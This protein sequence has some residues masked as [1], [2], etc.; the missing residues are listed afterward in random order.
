[1]SDETDVLDV[2]VADQL[3]LHDFGTITNDGF[4][5][6]GGYSGFDDYPRYFTC[7]EALVSLAYDCA[8]DVVGE[9]HVFVGT[10][11]TGDQFVSS[12]KYVK[13]LQDEFQAL[14]CEMEGAAIAIVCAQYDVPYVVIRTMSDKADGLAHET[15]DN[16]LDIAA[17]NSGRIVMEMLKSMK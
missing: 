4:E 15:I 17:N 10:I 16:M 13:K 14:A 12:E 1:M 8:V 7:D 5:W 11:A 9:D 6:Y 2:V 3:L